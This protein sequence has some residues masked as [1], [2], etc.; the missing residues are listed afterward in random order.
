MEEKEVWY[1]FEDRREADYDPWAEY[2]QPHT[3]HI[4]VNIVEYLVLKHTPKGVWISSN[5]GFSSKRFVLNRSNKRFACPT[6]K[7]A[8]ESFLA[9]KKRQRDIN[10]VRAKSAE[11]AMEIAKDMMT[12]V[13][14]NLLSA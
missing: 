5:N 8:Y 9:R 2:D 14:G 7:E 1:R 3:S 11:R 13:Y 6:K 12:D 4:V 10:L